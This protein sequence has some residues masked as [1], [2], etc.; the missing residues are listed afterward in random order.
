MKIHHIFILFLFFTLCKAT[1]SQTV[2]PARPSKI[3]IIYHLHCD[4]LAENQ[5]VLSLVYLFKP[6]AKTCSL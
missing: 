2:V 1:M 5:F 3:Q 4:I 6:I